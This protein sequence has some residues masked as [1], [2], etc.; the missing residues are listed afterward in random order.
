MIVEPPK[1]WVPISQAARRKH[2][3]NHQGH[4]FSHLPPFEA[5]SIIA[6]PLIPHTAPPPVAFTVI[7]S[8]SAMV[9]LVIEL[10]SV[11]PIVICAVAPPLIHIP[12]ISSAHTD[13]YDL[14]LEDI[15][16]RPQLLIFDDSYC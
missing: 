14:L 11:S 8:S 9:P 4:I 10:I 1:Q 12:V 5:P 7:T 16:Q 3:A 13:K 2:V 15:M 6:T